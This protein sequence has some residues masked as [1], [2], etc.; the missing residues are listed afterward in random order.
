VDGL[1][2][3]M[4]DFITKERRACMKQESLRLARHGTE[5]E[6]ATLSYVDTAAAWGKYFPSD[7]V[8]IE[9]KKPR[10]VFLYKVTDTFF[11]HFNT[12]KHLALVEEEKKKVEFWISEMTKEIK[13]CGNNALLR[14][15]KAKLESYTELLDF[16]KE[17]PAELREIENEEL[18][19]QRLE[20]AS[21]RKEAKQAKKKFLKLKPKYEQLIKTAQKFSGGV[22]ELDDWKYRYFF[23]DN[24]D[25]ELK[26]LNHI[27]KHSFSDNDLNWLVKESL[28]E[29]DSGQFN[30]WNTRVVFFKFF[31]A[32]KS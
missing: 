15:K 31:A 7:H 23:G 22:V 25:A 10:W 6:R 17:I 29:D 2:N 30:N 16:L 27:K 28:N 5:L 1:P 8:L 9:G 21:R 20:E 14:Q 19:E 13:E 24:F 11:Y 32:K 26:M 18:E 4:R 12:E 3:A